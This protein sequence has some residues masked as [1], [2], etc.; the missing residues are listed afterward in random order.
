MDQSTRV[1]GL[2]AQGNMV[3]T[4]VKPVMGLFQVSSSDQVG[5]VTQGGMGLQ[6][7]AENTLVLPPTQDQVSLET[8]Q[9]EMEAV[10]PQMQGPAPVQAEEAVQNQGPPQNSDFSTQMPFAEVSSLLD[11]NMKGSKARKHLIS[12]E[13]IKRRLQAPEKMSLRSLAAYTRV[14]RGPA[15]KKT[16]L[17]SLNVLGLTPSTTT[18]VSSSFSKLTEGDTRALCEDMKDFSHDY[19][20]YGNMAK[21][22]IPET[23]TVQHWSKIIETKNHLEDMRKCFKDPTNSGSFDSVTHG[24]GLGMLDVALDVIV[25]VIEQQIHILSGAAATVGTS[26]SAR[27]TQRIRRRQRKTSNR[28]SLGVKE[29]GKVISKG[30]G[31]SRVKKEIHQEGG[32]AS[33]VQPCKMDDMQDNVI[34]LVAVGYETVSTGL[35]GSTPA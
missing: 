10:Q 9:V 21:Q 8:T 5:T 30:K 17:E 27:H 28:A 3:F 20:D 11:P 26:H 35:A 19:I 34:T 18:S 31:P 25:M 22:L 15:S 6:G 23:N 24:L 7:L 29:Q 14:S 13:E 12:Y 2:D 32:A 4:V 1:L 33:P 16:L